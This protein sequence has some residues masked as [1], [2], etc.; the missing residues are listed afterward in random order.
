MTWIAIAKKD[1]RDAV[2]SRALWAL[3]AVFV[4][5]SVLSSYAYVEVP[6]LFGEPGGATFGGLILFMVGLIGLFVPI[7]AI[8]V[9]YKSLAGER[10]LGSIKLL[11]SLPTTRSN[12]FAGKLVGRGAVLAFGLAVGLVIGLGFGSVLLGEFEPLS[13]LLVILATMAF[14]AVY[15]GIIVGLSATTG[16]TS[17]AT[18][19]SLGFFVIFEL[20]WDV[21]PM[22]VL[23][24]VEGFRL[25]TETPDWIFLV[26][27]LSPSTAYFSSIV[28]L[29]PDLANASGSSAQTGV[30]A[31]GVEADPFYVTPTVGI[32]VLVL[33]LVVPFV[34]GYHR[35]NSADL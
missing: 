26:T 10:E 20:F 21:V 5:L 29:L 25:P 23:Y 4:S 16:S 8:V 14:A 33:W 13:A 28:A 17:R 19:L 34:V 15:S 1:F 32:I 7:A 12:V 3:V 31:A 9:C 22:G 6:E 11:L 24:V 2:Q 18:T 27:Q 30:R 35:F